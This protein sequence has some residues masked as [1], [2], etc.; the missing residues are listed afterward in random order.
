MSSEVK[1][2]LKDLFKNAFLSSSMFDD[3]LK[4]YRKVCRFFCVQVQEQGR[5][6]IRVS[7]P[8]E[9]DPIYFS[10]VSATLLNK[11]ATETYFLI[12]A[13]VTGVSMCQ[14]GRRNVIHCG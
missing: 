11:P 5:I 6:R 14:F 9:P 4:V 10:F 8:M 2:S 13:P 7:I 3:S 12:P 1:E